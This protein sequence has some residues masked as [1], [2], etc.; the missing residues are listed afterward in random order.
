[1]LLSIALGLSVTDGW[2]ATPMGQHGGKNQK[3]LSF[4]DLKRAAPLF[5]HKKPRHATS[6]CLDDIFGCLGALRGLRSDK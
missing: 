2:C 5:N 1:M 6:G 4:D 3:D